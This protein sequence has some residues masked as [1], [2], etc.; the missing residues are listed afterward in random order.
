MRLAAAALRTSQSALGAYYRRMCARMDKAKSVTAAARKLARLTSAML[1]Q[2]KEYTDQ[3]QDDLEERYRQR[4][5][6][7]LSRRA[8]QLEMKLVP[9]TPTDCSSVRPPRRRQWNLLLGGRFLR[10]P[11]LT[12]QALKG[13]AGFFDLSLL[14]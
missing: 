5:L 13:F 3:G 2:G 1:T 10:G 14:F 9:E 6:A 11:M 7:S 12:C 8:Q 4:V